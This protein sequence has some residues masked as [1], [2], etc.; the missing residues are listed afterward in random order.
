MGSYMAWHVASMVCCGV[1][2]VRTKSRIRPATSNHS[3]P[4]SQAN[5]H[6]ALH[7]PLHILLSIRRYIEVQAKAKFQVSRVVNTFR[8]PSIISSVGD[9]TQEIPGLLLGCGTR[10]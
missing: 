1:R 9:E 8:L 2:C 10:S 4:T 5:K 7:S 6:G 3:I